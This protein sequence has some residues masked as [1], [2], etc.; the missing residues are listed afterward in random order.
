MRYW[1]RIGVLMIISAVFSA[2][3]DEIDKSGSLPEAQTKQ[4]TY[5]IW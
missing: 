4:V 2:C 1:F 5:Y 3:E